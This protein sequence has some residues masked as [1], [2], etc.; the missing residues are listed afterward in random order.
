MTRLLRPYVRKCHVVAQITQGASSAAYPS[1]IGP[2]RRSKRK[3]YR[4]ENPPHLGVNV[5]PNR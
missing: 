4:P 2:R 3:P 5:M 1:G